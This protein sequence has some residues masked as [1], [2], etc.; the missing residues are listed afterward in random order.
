MLNKINL[1]VA[2]IGALLLGIL[3]GIVIGIFVSKMNFR[4][5]NHAN[6][7]LNVANKINEIKKDRQ[8]TKEDVREL[9]LS[10]NYRQEVVGDLYI[11]LDNLNVPNPDSS[12]ILTFNNRGMAV[13]G[14]GHVGNVFNPFRNEK[15]K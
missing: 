7:L 10:L 2:I 9:V 13:F 5:I 3:M 4:V 1:N 6:I 8:I 11:N 12:D 14:D 15:F